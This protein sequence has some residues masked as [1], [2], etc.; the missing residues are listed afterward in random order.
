MENPTSIEQLMQQMPEAFLPAKAGNVNAV[1]QFNLTGEGGGNYVVSIADGKCTVA[2]GTTP[3][4]NATVTAAAADY[5][6]I[7]RGELNPMTA[8]MT[9]KIRVTGDMGLMMRFL[10][11]FARPTPGPAPTGR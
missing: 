8:F 9:G 3:T 5:L 10:D 4:P 11:W 7:V 6:A 2:Q 1:V